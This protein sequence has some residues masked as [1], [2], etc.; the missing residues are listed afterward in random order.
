MSRLA[1]PR[2][3]LI[4]RRELALARSM[5]E[6]K[7]LVDE[8]ESAAL[9]IQRLGISFTVIDDL[10]SQRIDIV[11]NLNSAQLP[12]E[13]L[14]R[15]FRLYISSWSIGMDVSDSIGRE[16][17][18]LEPYKP[19]IIIPESGTINS[20][21]RCIRNEVSRWV[22]TERTE[23]I[24]EI[25]LIRTLVKQNGNVREDRA[26]VHSLRD[27][28]QAISLVAVISLLKA[29][30]SV[31]GV[32]NKLEDIS[33]YVSS[34]WGAKLDALV[35]LEKKK[36]RSIQ[37]TSFVTRI[38]CRIIFPEALAALDK[39]SRASTRTSRTNHSDSLDGGYSVPSQPQVQLADDAE[40][41]CKR[42][43]RLYRLMNS[44]SDY[45]IR[46]IF[47]ELY[48]LLMGGPKEE[49]LKL[50]IEKRELRTLF[51]ELLNQGLEPKD[52]AE[53]INSGVRSTESALDSLTRPTDSA[54]TAGAIETV[55]IT[56]AGRRTKTT[57][58]SSVKPLDHQ[59]VTRQVI[60][61]AVY[62]RYGCSIEGLDP[63]RKPL[64]KTAINHITSFVSSY[65]EY[66]SKP[67][68]ER[69]LFATDGT[70][71]N[72]LFKEKRS[73]NSSD[74]WR[75]FALN[76]GD[77][78][79]VL[80]VRPQTNEFGIY[81]VQSNHPTYARE[82]ATF[83]PEYLKNKVRILVSTDSIKTQIVNGS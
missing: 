43:P 28:D 69:G 4:A 6:V 23:A 75:L 68:G 22:R 66:L 16:V 39:Q 55:K 57:P 25:R 61:D 76:I 12:L 60:N 44:D 52:A 27:A 79:V 37:E 31:E 48:R 71:P 14:I 45:S 34:G 41:I 21:I 35:P 73:T 59:R 32:F 77:S 47:P 50:K 7:P 64:I 81:T 67:E 1:P 83:L 3:T 70:I 40:E 2:W 72:C 53:L 24:D 19:V 26:T 10:V 8:F 65:M 20:K 42:F 62:A 74:N 63:I 38:R 51:R 80:A 5:R 36:H 54:E 49:H 30:A 11:Y 17:S 9:Q 82:V 56:N 46:Y 13:D 78:R 29:M 15:V 18:V 33:S 58:T